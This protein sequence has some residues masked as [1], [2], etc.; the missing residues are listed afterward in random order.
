ME[1]FITLTPE[2]ID[3]EHI[4]CAISDKKCQEGYQKKRE[5]LKQELQHGYVFRRLDARA[6]VFMEYGPAE[7]AWAPIVAPN[8]I[9]IHCF[10]VSGR[11]KGQGYAKRLLQDAIED[12][13]SQNRAGLVTIVGTKKFHFM[14][15]TK[16]LLRQ[17]FEEVERL[18][19]GFSLLCLKF[20]SDGITPSFGS[21]V[22]QTELHSREDITVYYS[23]RCPFT[24]YH[25]NRSL[26]ESTQN[27]NL[28]LRIIKIECLE[29]AQSA[30]TPATIFSLFYRG[31]FVTTDISVC[32]D[33]RFDKIMKQ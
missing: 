10:W 20:D 25:V 3:Q 24:E 29:Q 19:S 15:D 2:N 30:P 23:N 16:W 4:C 18:P 28:S 27:R 11:Y 12:A 22:Q 9:H 13:R 17:G 1:E 31:Q 21:S 6:K 7:R 14:S 8:F 5:W 33:S 26:V 32:M